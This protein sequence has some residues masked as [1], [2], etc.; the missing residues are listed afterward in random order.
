[1]TKSIVIRRAGP[2][3]ADGLGTCLEAAYAADAAR[4][5]DLPAM[6]EG[7]AED[8]A[9]HLV[10]VAEAEGQILGGLVLIPRDGF[11]LL[12]NVAVHPDGRGTGIGRRLLELAETEAVARGHDE[13]R[14]NTH[15]EMADTIALYARNGWIETGRK[16][17]KVSMRKALGR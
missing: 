10:W 6:A 13:M 4:I 16:G 8:I 11:M 14:L 17:T 7:C 12:A 3:D 9:E 15:A 1:M 2:E 5:H